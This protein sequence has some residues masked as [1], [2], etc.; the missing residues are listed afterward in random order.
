MHRI[1]EFLKERLDRI[2]IENQL[3]KAGFA[4]LPYL[5]MR[6][7]ALSVGARLTYA[8]L[9]MYA[10]QEDN[11][12]AGQ[13]RMAA[14]MGISDRHL[15]RYLD[16]L[17]HAEYIRIERKDKRFNNTYVILDKQPTKLKR[18]HAARRPDLERTRVSS[19]NGHNRHAGQDVR[20]RSIH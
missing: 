15:R 13:K 18:R 19:P 20:V 1:G 2:I 4:A 8:F 16:E 14:D 10:W 3:M 6:D 9:L 5:V 12:F 17:K 11:C 7:S